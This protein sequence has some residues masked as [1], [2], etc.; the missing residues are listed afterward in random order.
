MKNLLSM[1][2]NSIK[3]INI[4]S[5]GIVRVNFSPPKEECRYKVALVV[6]PLIKSSEECE[7]VIFH[8]KGIDVQ[9]VHTAEKS[10]CI[11]NN[12]LN[13]SQESQTPYC[14]V[15]EF[16]FYTFEIYKNLQGFTRII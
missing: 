6:N 15:R 14:Q 12:H 11:F 1:I 5:A 16:F 3:S 9:E 2:N 8:A 13:K 4:F 7:K 10:Y